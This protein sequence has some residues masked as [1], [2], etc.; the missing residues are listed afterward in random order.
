MKTFVS[1]LILTVILGCQEHSPAPVT[2]P[3]CIQEIIERIQKED[4]WNPP[5]K[6][7]RYDYKDQD[8]YYIPAHCCDF[9]SMVIV[10]CRLFCAPDGGFTGKGDGRCPEFLK[11]AQNPVLIWEDNRN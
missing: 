9:P 4:S 11:E 3:E 2:V 5:A 7:Y 10:D 6:I 8:A 1:T